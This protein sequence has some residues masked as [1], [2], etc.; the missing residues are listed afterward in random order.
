M[1]SLFV[2][3]PSAG[4]PFMAQ[5]RFAVAARPPKPNVDGKVTLPL[6]MSWKFFHSRT[7]LLSCKWMEVKSGLRLL[8]LCQPGRRRRGKE[9]RKHN[10]LFTHLS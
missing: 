3:V 7:R 8:A 10:L 5:V 6:E 2:E 9:S 4:I 1:Q